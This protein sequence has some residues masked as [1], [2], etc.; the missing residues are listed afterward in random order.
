MPGRHYYGFRQSSRGNWEGLCHPSPWSRCGRV[1]KVHCWEYGWQPVPIG[2]MGE[3]CPPPPAPQRGAPVKL[4]DAIV[5]QPPPPA[6]ETR[7]TPVPCKRPG[8]K[9]SVTGG[10]IARNHRE[11][12]RPRQPSF[13]LGF[14]RIKPCTVLRRMPPIGL[15]QWMPM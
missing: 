5:L 14:C 12:S 1:T 8:S 10:L 11:S 13:D 9:A 15:C 7:Q 4:E 6:M 3:R 2:P